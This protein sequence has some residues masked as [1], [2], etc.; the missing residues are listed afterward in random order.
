MEGE[1]GKRRERKPKQQKERQP[2]PELLW[3]GELHLEF[4]ESGV[5]R[6]I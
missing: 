5:R 6:V 4:S 1:E 2:S 3:D